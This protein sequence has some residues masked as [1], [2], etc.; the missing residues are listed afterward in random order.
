MRIF[1]D[2]LGD[3]C[4]I[5]DKFVRCEKIKRTS[6]DLRPTKKMRLF[7]VRRLRTSIAKSLFPFG[8]FYSTSL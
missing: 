1:G 2:L 6:I 5:L 8:S 7:V 4:G 3:F